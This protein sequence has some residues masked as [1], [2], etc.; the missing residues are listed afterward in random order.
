VCF[1]FVLTSILDVYILVFID[2]LVFS[3][4]ISWF[5]FDPYRHIV[6]DIEFCTFEFRT[7]MIFIFHAI[8][9]HCCQSV[10]FSE[11]CY[12]SNFFCNNDW[13][14]W[15]GIFLKSRKGRLS[16]RFRCIGHWRVFFDIYWLI[17]DRV[18][19]YLG[20]FNVV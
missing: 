5:F 19:H 2:F 14:I 6:F 8:I 9:N 4:R 13:I 1:L 20:I 17:C 12:N 15:W 16:Y 11:T 18:G 7:F 3:R 10:F